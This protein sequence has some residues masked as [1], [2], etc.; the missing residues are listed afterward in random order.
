MPTTEL[1]PKETEQERIERWRTEML[2]RAG[3]SAAAAAELAVRM[4]VDLHQAM[5]LVENGCPPDVA[6]QILR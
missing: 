3:Y 1:Q 6:L 5:R 4:D 2:E